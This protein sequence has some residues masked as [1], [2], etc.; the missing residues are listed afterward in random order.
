MGGGLVA[1][2]KSVTVPFFKCVD[3]LLLLVINGLLSVLSLFLQFSE[4]AVSRSVLLLEVLKFSQ[5]LKFFFV[6]DLRVFSSR[7]F[8]PICV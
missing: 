4:L 8:E 1:F 7:V 6:N 5:P 3:Q 2:F